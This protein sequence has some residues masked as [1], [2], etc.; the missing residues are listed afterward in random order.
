[1]DY[2]KF[3]TPPHIAS[4]LI[5]QLKV[6]APDVIID[7][8]C[9]S[10][11]LLNAANNRWR[12]SKLVGVDIVTHSN[13][14]V[15]CIQSDGRKYAIENSNLYPL[16]LA[17]PPFHFIEEKG[18]FP[19]LY[20]GLPCG[21]ATSRLEIEM[22]LANLRLL[23]KDGTL[24]IIMPSTFVNADSNRK[25]RKYIA[26]KYQVQQIISLPEDAFGAS[27][28]STYAL[29]IK[30]KNSVYRQTNYRYICL[31]DGQF[32]ISESVI[33]PVKQVGDGIW[34]I[35]SISQDQ[36]PEFD[37]KRGTISSQFFEP[38]GI[39]VL[40]TAKQQRNWVPA[41]RYTS[42]INV[43]P[44]YAEH[45]DVVVSRI[46]KS[47]GQWC[48]YKGEK[49]LISDCLYRIKDTKGTIA[50][51]LHGHDYSFPRK[52]VATRYI[53]MKDFY[54]WYRTLAE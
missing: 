34:D 5:N 54:A 41:V 19:E 25:I 36:K 15:L 33:I 31:A 16:V 27:K 13:S 28:I 21:F 17:N 30:N 52:G 3:Y 23:K 8:C 10:Y 50:K 38:T 26:S 35:S 44:V 24:L 20:S 11:N 51:R 48:I 43:Q 49:M 42:Q 18:V 45:G 6:N 39:P 2:S 46:G 40:H 22:L 14:N 32:V 47:A 1:M 7:I 53:T 9:G 12:K 37:Y 4:L 29:V